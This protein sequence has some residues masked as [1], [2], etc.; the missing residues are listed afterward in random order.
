MSWP[1]I[2]CIDFH[3]GRRIILNVHLRDNFTYR[4]TLDSLECLNNSQKILRLSQKDNKTLV[5]VFK[6]NT[7]QFLS[8]KMVSPRLLRYYSTRQAALKL[9]VK[10]NGAPSTQVPIKGCTNIDDF[11]EKVKQKLN[12]NS[13]VALYSS[14]DKEPIKPWLE[15]KDLLETDLRKNSGETPLFVKLIPISQESIASKTIYFRD[16]D[17]DG[18]FSDEYVP[19]T[20]KNNEDVRALYKDGKGLICLTGPKKL[21]VSFDEIEDGKKYQVYNYSQD[22]KR[23]KRTQWR[24][25]H[26]YP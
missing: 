18:D 4:L 26:Y 12:T 3:K 15:I 1:E 8:S 10:H 13:Q 6:K 11:A 9:W 16:I 20:V 2:I 17:D 23:R 14:L 21:I 22:F 7:M 25:R 5:F 19:V 24:Q